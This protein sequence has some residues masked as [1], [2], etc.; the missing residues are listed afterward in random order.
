MAVPTKI[1]IEEDRIL[2]GDALRA[3][4]ETILPSTKQKAIFISAYITQS[5]VD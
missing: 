1:T 2:D 5:G 3:E 4:L